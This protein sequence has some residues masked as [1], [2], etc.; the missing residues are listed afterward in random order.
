MT[1]PAP[2][3][4]GTFEQTPLAHVL[5]YVRERG[6]SGSLLVRNDKEKTIVA[7]E[8]G[9]LAQC[10]LPPA[11][12]LNGATPHRLGDVMVSL[13]LVSP[14]AL[15]ESIEHMVRTATLQGQALV[16]I[17]ACEQK[18]VDLAL[19]EQ[20]AR[21][22]GTLFV[23]CA[24]ARYQF[25]ADHDMLEGFG[26]ERVHVDVLSVLW[27]GLRGG[28][29]DTAMPRMLGQLAG[30]TVR[31][32]GGVDLRLY[33][34]ESALAPLLEALR[35][36][37]GVEALVSRAAD[38]EVGR[39]L[40]YVLRVSKALELVPG[41]RSAT[42]LPPPAMPASMAPPSPSPAMPSL[43]PRAPSVRAPI[44]EV[45]GSTP[46]VIPSPLVPRL[47]VPPSSAPELERTSHAPARA[48]VP[49]TAAKA[50]APEPAPRVS[51]PPASR[52]S[53]PE[54]TLR[55][56]DDVLQEARRLRATDLHVVAERPALFRLVGELIPR[57]PQWD[58]AAVEKMVMPL[59]PER[60]RKTLEEQGSCDFA[61]EHPR[62][63]RFR[64]N[65][66][67][68]RTGL[69]LCMRL[70]LPEVPTLESLGLPEA[71][72]KATHHHQGLIVL[73]G[74]TGHGKTSTLTAL[75]DLLNRTTTHHIITVED[76]VEYL[77]PRV[78]AMMS[79]R[80]VGSHTQTF[81][82]ALKA[83]LREDPDVIAIGELRDTETVRMALAAS[84]TGHL[85][86]STMNTP[87]AAKTIERLI[88][89]FPPA[90][91]PQVRATLA[92]GLRMVVSQ[93]LVPRADGS[94]MAAA[95]ELLP[96]N[97]ALWNLIRDNKTYQ[98][99]SLQQRGK[100]M[101][102]VRLDDSLAELVHKGTCTLEA[103]RFYAE[104]PEEFPNLVKGLSAPPPTAQEPAKE[105]PAAGGLRSLFG[106]KG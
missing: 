56:M 91:Q 64:A 11:D 74:P 101:G 32:R 94:G 58:A 83:S 88:D 84:E 15:S 28:A 5:L 22:L 46:L 80:E 7:F 16:A 14:K 76:P 35:G 68:Q 57:G 4:E 85:V 102:I 73:T 86:I 39:R 66:G 92:G 13:R 24:E 23:Q 89:L 38:P 43:P 54:S 25:F 2:T 40:L 106:K 82:S 93:R 8:R 99:P 36:G 33:A 20:L 98:I 96:G 87:N 34:F 79:Q 51:V 3:A 30:Q 50:P 75:L 1:Q 81:A 12:E 29:P 53:Q 21:K 90:D 37:V 67:R 52:P 70:I 18:S 41:A 104:S 95:V 63:G 17:G 78:S 31:L 97:L 62:L 42:S 19:R 9:Y 48:S 60:A 49:P 10:S 27:R 105:Q 71:I 59:V 61:Y 6:L 55:T 72:A 103:A 69:K 26:A 44:T 45:S 65:V 47:S 77:H 100:A